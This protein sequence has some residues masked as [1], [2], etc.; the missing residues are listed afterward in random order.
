M[1]HNEESP[2]CLGAHWA[3]FYILGMLYSSKGDCNHVTEV[4]NTVK[5][6]QD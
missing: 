6:S 3:I 1:S 2:A 4:G 5:H